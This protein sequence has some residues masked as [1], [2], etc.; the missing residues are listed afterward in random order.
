ERRLAYIILTFILV[1]GAGFVGYQ[2]YLQPMSTYARQITDLEHDID[3]LEDAR[4]KVLTERKRLESFAKISLPFTPNTRPEADIARRTDVARGN[5]VEKL[6][7]M[8]QKSGFDPRSIDVKDKKP[9]NKS[10]PQFKGKAA[11]P[12]GKDAAIYTR[13]EFNVEA[14]GNLAS[15]T[16]WMEQFYKLQLLHQI[17]NLT[18][19]RR[20]TRRR[21]ASRTNSTSRW[22]STRW[23][24]TRP[25]SAR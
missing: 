20:S 6:I 16:K 21:A 7:D 14:K 4:K 8:L 23:S 18:I 11:P 10:S 1:A 9:D 3:D 5:Y 15:L 13:L 24:S 12:K 17:K 22:R 2:F 25:S 19:M